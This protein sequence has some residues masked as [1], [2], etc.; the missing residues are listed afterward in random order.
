MKGVIIALE[1]DRRLRR[2]LKV[3]SN[4]DFYRY[5]VSFKL[6]RGDW[7][8][9]WSRRMSLRCNL[10]VHFFNYLSLI[11]EGGDAKENT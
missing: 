8:G 6:S 11:L 7:A 4:I 3:T 5:E 1:D 2:A 10:E 9:Y